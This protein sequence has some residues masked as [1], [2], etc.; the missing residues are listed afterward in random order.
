MDIT[1]A[2]P[3][4]DI[5]AAI[6]SE[7]FSRPRSKKI[8]VQASP[9]FK[10]LYL[11]L[12]EDQRGQDAISTAAQNLAIT[13]DV[14]SQWKHWVEFETRRRLVLSAFMWDV[15]QATLFKQSLCDPSMDP[16]AT[17]LYL[18]CPKQVWDCNSPDEW[19]NMRNLAPQ[20]SSQLS[21]AVKVLASAGPQPQPLGEF[22]SALT[23]TS[24]MSIAIAIDQED[25]DHVAATASASGKR[26]DLESSY[27][28]WWH[29]YFNSSRGSNSTVT[30]RTPRDPGTLLM[31]HMALLTLHTDIRDLL[32]VAGESFVFGQKRQ[33]ADYLQAKRDLRSW[34]N[35]PSAAAKAAWHAAKILRIA[36]SATEKA[37]AMTLTTHWCMHIAGLVC[38]AYGYAHTVRPSLPLP[39][40]PSPSTGEAAKTAWP[41]LEATNT[42]SWEELDTVEMRCRTTGLLIHVRT[43]LERSTRGECQ[44]LSE[45]AQ[46]LRRLA[47]RRATFCGF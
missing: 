4:P 8:D 43:A 7:M 30:T 44:L 47:E 29:S 3:I 23:L 46:V 16:A 28:R 17:G 11:S 37:S 38:W 35:T 33:K 40:P 18:P 2:S 31:Y 12:L 26:K 27:E 9:E 32:T 41:Y 14:S 36:L 34:A 15:Q 21:D 39:Q 42:R 6:L 13:Q 5:Q 19:A 25:S 22:A 10:K 1:S 24:L 45:G 20:E